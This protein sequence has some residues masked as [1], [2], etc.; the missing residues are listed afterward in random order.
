[1]SENKDP[2]R[3]IPSVEAIVSGA[4]QVADAMVP[5]PLLT[6][7]TRELVDEMRAHPD[8]APKHLD[9]WIALARHRT[10]QRLRPSLRPVI[11][12]TGVV[13][14]TNLG[15]APMPR[16]AIAAIVAAAAGYSNLEYDLASGE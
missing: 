13:L 5:R 4:E 6:D 11:N 10:E 7:V 16:A 3:A 14:H 2:R 8:R 1:M 9:D 12:A 15:R